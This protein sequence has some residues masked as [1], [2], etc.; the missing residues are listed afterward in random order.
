MDGSDSKP[1]IMSLP[2]QSASLLRPAGPLDMSSAP[3]LRPS[4][5]L[6]ARLAAPLPRSVALLLRE[7]GSPES[8][9]TLP[10]AP[11]AVSPGKQVLPHQWHPRCLGLEEEDGEGQLNVKN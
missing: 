11:V 7:N 6:L 9:P 8:S 1:T 3:L 10:S 2:R 5:T 4:A